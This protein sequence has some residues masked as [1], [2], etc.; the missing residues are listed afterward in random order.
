MC[1]VAADAGLILLNL[2]FASDVIAG[3]FVGVSTGLFTVALCAANIGSGQ[4]FQN[5]DLHL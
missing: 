1:I 2:H 3:T 5:T 4:T